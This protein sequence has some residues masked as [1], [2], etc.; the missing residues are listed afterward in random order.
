MGSARGPLLTVGDR[1]IHLV[2]NYEPG[3]F[4][5]AQALYFSKKIFS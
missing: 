1:E 3:H 5:S 4:L 2:I